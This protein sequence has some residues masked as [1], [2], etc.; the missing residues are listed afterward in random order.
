MTWSTGIADLRHARRTTLRGDVIGGLT[1]TAYSVPQVMAYSSLAGLPPQTGLWVVALTMVVYFFLGSSRLLSSGPE[2][3][4]ALLTAAVIAPLAAG[5]PQRYA[6]LAALLALLCGA[7]AIIAWLLKLGF[8]GDLLSKPVLVGYMAGVAVIMITSQIG[9]VSGLDVAGDSFITEVRSFWSSVQ[10]SGLSWPSVVMGVAVAGLLIVLTPRFPRV[11]MPVI[12]VALAAVAAS[13]LSSRGMAIP[14]V[15]AIDS[16]PPDIGLAG[17]TTADAIALVLPAMGVF[18]VAYTDNLLTARMFAVR[19]RQHI[20]SNRELLALGASN[21]ASA[22]VS[23]FPVSSSASRAVIGEASGARTQ[24]ASLVAA[25]GVLT[26]LIGLP[27]VLASFPVAALGGLVIYA[28][29]RLVDVSEFRRLWSF[30]RRE[31]AL[32]VGAAASVLAFDILYGVIA[33]IV[34]SIIELLTRV[35]R[36]HAAVLGQAPGVAGWHDVDDYPG[37]E[38]VPGLLVYRYD[39]PLFFANAD[40]FRRRVEAAVDSLQPR[41]RWLLLNMEANVEVDIT[42]LDA[43]ERIRRHCDDEGVIVALVRVK[44]DV[45]ED[46]RRHG[47]AKRIGEDRVYPTLP[48]AVQGF[49]E[50]QQSQD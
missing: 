6:S 38:Q 25:A 2:S 15:G 21:L 20:D 12:V 22:A 40:D 4:T 13:V 32:A 16:R 29:T 11:P 8:I 17:V 34:L 39:S 27:G 35:A 23:G 5:D 44:H 10:E 33:A 18:I 37:A 26:V 36:P 19:H 47:V 24:A 45:L 50:W 30:R 42:G 14:T 1:V 31:F 9:K 7:C 41:P 3:S 28:A 49:L 46:L 48:T 43:M